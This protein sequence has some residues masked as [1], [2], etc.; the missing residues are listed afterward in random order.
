MSGID[1]DD[2]F[3]WSF[4]VS[5]KAIDYLAAGQTL[6]QSYAVKLDD[7]HGGTADQ[8]VTITIVGAAD[9]ATK[10]NNGKGG[11]GAASPANSIE[12]AGGPDDHSIV[13]DQ[14]PV[15]TTDA[16]SFKSNGHPQQDDPSLM[17][18]ASALSDISVYIA[19]GEALHHDWLLH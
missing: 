2:F 1:T 13:Q 17:N 16:V 7:S 8:T 4:S 14:M 6:T 5:D 10:G 15:Q 18:P 19:Q 3:D 9:A 11:K 12:V